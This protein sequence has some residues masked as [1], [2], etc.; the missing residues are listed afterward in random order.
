MDTLVDSSSVLF[1]SFSSHDK[2]LYDSKTDLYTY[3]VGRGFLFFPSP[4]P[5]SLPAIPS[6]TLY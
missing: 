1:L 6:L 2:V 4:F 5:P 3:K